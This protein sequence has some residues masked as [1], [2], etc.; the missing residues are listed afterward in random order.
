[1][2]KFSNFLLTKK[3]KKG[4]G[5]KRFTHRSQHG[6]MLVEIILI[7]VFLAT[8][9]IGTSYFFAQTKVTMSSSSQVTQCSTIA[10][11]ALENVVSLGARLYGYRINYYTNSAFSY[12]P[13]FIKD[14][15]GGG[16]KDVGSG[17]ELSFPP[18]MYKTLYTNLGVSP[19]IG[20]PQSNTGKPLI[21][22]SYPY[23]ISTAVLIVN[24]VNA[25]QYLYNSDNGF[26][27]GS[28]GKMHTAGGNGNMS[29]LL[30]KYEDQFDLAGMK[31]YIKVTP[32]DLQTEEEVASPPSQILT[33]PRFHN[34]Q[35]AQLSPALTVL[36]DPEVGFEI[37][38][39][40][41]YE[42]GNQEYTCD[43]SHRF[44]HQIKPITKG[45]ESIFVN[46]VSLVSGAGID[47]NTIPS[48]GELT[49]CDTHG[50][51]SFRDIT[52]TVDFNNFY[53]G[54]KSSEQIGTV[55][56]CQMN[57]Y[58]R[59]YGDASYNGCNPQLG[60]WQ[61]CHDIQPTDPDQNWTYT[62]ELTSDQVLAMKFGAMKVDRRYE[63]NV[64][65]F[66]MA[67]HNLRKEMVSKFYIDAKRPIISGKNIT[68]NAVGAPGDGG[69]GG[70]Y[71]GP[72][73]N[74]IKPGDSTNKWLQCNQDTV[75]FSADIEDQ[76]THNLEKCELKGERE[77]GNGTAATSP[78]LTSDCGGELS[79]VQQG[80]QT[81]TFT[82]KDTCE[83]GPWNTEDLVWDT[84]LPS[85]FE[86]HDFPND[87]EWLKSTDKDAY[88]IKT[89]LPAKD[90]VGEFPK[91]YSVDCNDNFMGS[92]A[93]KDGDGGQ[94][95]CKL[96]GSKPYHD[97]G[98]NPIQFSTKYHHVCGGTGSGV[99][100]DTKWSV[101]VPENENC[102]NVE[103]EPDLICCDNYPDKSCTTDI[104]YKKAT[105][106]PECTNPKGGENQD[107]PSQCNVDLG[108]Y[109]CEYYLPCLGKNQKTP[110]SGNECWGTGP[111]C[112]GK[113]AG[114]ACGFS[115]SAPPCV[116]NDTSWNSYS[117][118][119]DGKQ[120]GHYCGGPD[121]P[122][123][124]TYETFPCTANCNKRCKK[125]CTHTCYD[126]CH[127]SDTE[128]V[129]DQNGLNCQPQQVS[130]THIT[131]NPHD[132][133]NCDEWEYQAVT[134]IRNLSYDGACIS[135]TSGGCIS[136]DSGGGNLTQERCDARP[137][138]CPLGSGVTP[139]PCDP[140]VEC[141]GGTY[142]NNLNCPSDCVK[143]NGKACCLQSEG[144]DCQ[145]QFCAT[146]CASSGTCHVREINND[147]VCRPTCEDLA[148]AKGYTGDGASDTSNWTHTTSTCVSLNTQELW[149]STTWA[150]IPLID[151][152]EPQEVI[153]NGG[154]C[155]GRTPSACDSSKECCDLDK[156]SDLGGDNDNC[157]V[158]GECD[159]PNDGCKYGD[160]EDATPPDVTWIC[161]GK[162]EGDDSGVCGTCD[163]ALKCCDGQD[164]ST[165]PTHC[166][167]Q[168]I[169]GVCDLPNHDCKKG[170]KNTINAN[171][172]ECLGEHTGQ[173]DTCEIVCDSTVECCSTDTDA[174]YHCPCRSGR[175]RATADP[176]GP[177]LV[178]RG[179]C[180]GGHQL[181]SCQVGNGRGSHSPPECSQPN[182][183]RMECSWICHG[184]MGADGQAINS[185]VC[186][187]EFSSGGGGGDGGDG[188]GG[189]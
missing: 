126:A 134:T 147:G 59:S 40:L 144:G 107:S 148:E 163:P 125:A 155:C 29:N 113:R 90:T 65:E 186:S 116:P 101:Y 80:R 188:G 122:K 83:P 100:K 47:L 169:D 85:K 61:R 38:V 36:G 52:V 26:N 121:T 46:E 79:G 103:C 27:S 86:T 37:K 170:E 13:L 48:P 117:C 172:W 58:C 93:R 20:N 135:H 124:L 23:D 3:K 115:S 53:G 11:Q 71:N 56:L 149:G 182:A 154:E 108:L 82:P 133:H 63:L 112:G 88:L 177:C 64:G 15:G 12:K 24:S 28:K 179:Q 174:N 132:C 51:P 39:T 162:N 137:G 16:I 151:N 75:E 165:N 104:C 77:D 57:S 96:E 34:P 78:T 2:F 45:S 4:G 35:G 74:W 18:E 175:Q 130:C 72:F 22:D 173:K 60:R 99:C 142:P 62:P 73:T 97:D 128:T 171:K 54:I 14:D 131:C 87:P 70:N 150:K 49:S 43:A 42:R 146:N 30:K 102:K 140:N 120:A 110:L 127:A 123:T 168:P 10:K 89:V 41:E 164:Y 25:L 157:L 106:T 178:L 6:M 19:S 159:T 17:S 68:N 81:I 92:R 160:K 156:H 50:D 129:C 95:D 118:K 32:I 44:T 84:D 31:F 1:M 119:S 153:E 109:E 158:N 76:F 9:A 176:R 69:G 181:G 5:V 55:V 91:H 167:P 67:S 7:A 145:G 8:V 143:A 183:G 33:R 111:G 187:G 189:D 185:E 105:V 166:I 136:R 180:A 141:C 94:L 66:S 21:G 138:S 152:K 161:K 98:C 139:P 114:E 184:V